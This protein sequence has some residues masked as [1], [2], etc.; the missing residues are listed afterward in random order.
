MLWL[1]RRLGYGVRLKPRS[2]WAGGRTR[3]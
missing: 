1:H 2:W 3:R